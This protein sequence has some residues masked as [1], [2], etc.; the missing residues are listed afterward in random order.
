MSTI[1][2]LP[3]PV[4]GTIA[5]NGRAYTGSVGTPRDVP[6]QD[7]DILGANGWVWVAWSGPTSAR[8]SPTRTTG[9]DSDS[10]SRFFDTTLSKLIVWDG[11]TWRDPATGS[12]V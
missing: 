12:A 3:P 11:A 7:A 10:A 9:V 8:P 2:M 4:A 6:T 5:A 1:R